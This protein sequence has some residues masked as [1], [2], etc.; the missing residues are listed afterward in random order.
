MPLN[1]LILKSAAKKTLYLSLTILVFGACSTRKDKFLNRNFQALNTEFNVLYNGNLALEEGLTDL[2]NNYKDNFWEVLPVERMQVAQEASMPGESRNPNF[3]RAEE[4]ATK[5][6]Q[7]R[8]MLIG[9]SE[10]NPQ[11]D[12]AHLLLG[13]A[14]YYD[15][16]FVP[17]LEAFN[18][19]LYKNPDSDKIYE[20]K[21]WRER[22]NIR[23]ENDALAV[24]NLRKLLSEIKFKDQV[25][26]DANASL[27][28]AFLNLEEQDSAV[29]RLRKALSYT[30]KDEEKARYRFILGQ[31]F[32]KQKQKDSAL[33]YYQSVINMKRKSPRRYVIQAHAK[34]AAYFD[35]QK[36][37]TLPFVTQFNKLIED[38]ENRPY[39]DVL[40]YQKGLF[41]EGMKMPDHA[42]IN[43]NKS[44]RAQSLDPYLL[45]SNYRNLGEIY[46]YKAKYQTSGQYYDS[47]L[48]LL[49]PRTREFKAIKKKRDNLVD[50]IKYEG[51]AQRNDSIL[52]V[53][54]LSKEDQI[55][56]YEAYITDLKKTNAKTAAQEKTNPTTESK[57]LSFKNSAS[58]TTGSSGSTFYF[59]NAATLAQGKLDFVKRW[60]KRS[61]G[62]YWRLNQKPGTSFVESPD[63]PEQEDDTVA[64]EEK[65]NPMYS[66]EFYLSQLPTSKIVIDSIAKERNFAYYQLGVIYKEKF[67]EYYLS[68]DRFEILLKSKP[69]ERLV[70]PALY[71]LYKVYEIINPTKSLTLKDKILTQFPDSRYAQILSKS[72]ASAD[73]MI[74]DPELVYKNLY[75][76]Y[77]NQDYRAVALETDLAIE[78]FTG[79]E[80]LPKFEL[81]KAS[82]VAKMK[83]IQDYKKSLNFVALTYP[84]AD[85]GKQAEELLYDNIPYLESL[86]FDQAPP[87]T[88]KILYRADNLEDKKTKELLEKISKFIKERNQ[89]QLSHSID[90]YTTDKN[91]IV[92]HGLKD[93]EYAKGVASILKE[94]KEYKIAEPFVIVSTENYKI[95]QIRK[96]LEEYLDPSLRVVPPPYIPKPKR[97]QAK[98]EQSEI[99][100]PMQNPAGTQNPGKGGS[101]MPPGGNDMPPAGG[102]TNSSGKGGNESNFQQQ[103]P[104]APNN[105]KKG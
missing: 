90:L 102:K 57:E 94:F 70:L 45:A 99:V 40:Y 17:A 105:T 65:D 82:L 20:A 28:Q 21:I 104:P 71:N 77:E 1:V 43:Y 54:S 5:A 100:I 73:T 15:Q 87:T 25:F 68:A 52:N 50:V 14:R 7:K 36:A 34:Q 59:Y 97:T 80:L 78:K 96:N 81:L 41:Y 86:Y 18:Y 13:K 48:V 56:F 58:L 46:F 42:V 29:V 88:Y 95:I 26:A 63:S 60:G 30:K 19:I 61:M 38:R 6:I 83:G 44:L 2:R 23:L 55:A 53:V 72:N 16:R 103:L 8:S 84:N 37:D 89:I 11:M 74:D 35:Y 76:R 66:P 92:I 24:K 27:A 33:H 64:K 3:E 51:I 10:K 47:T 9:G 69:E 39:L 12:E 32:D 101:L 49:Q 75:K 22:T 62:G 93:E 67:R 85:E 98:K 79:E 91:F 31:L 4:K